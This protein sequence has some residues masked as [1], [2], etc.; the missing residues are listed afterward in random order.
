MVPVV[1]AWFAPVVVEEGGLLSG[2]IF[3]LGLRACCGLFLAMP[4]WEDALKFVS[5]CLECDCL[6]RVHNY[7][8][9]QVGGSIGALLI[10]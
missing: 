4:R 2:L 8:C 7:V 5:L 10:W 1:V 9:Q 6:G 3:M